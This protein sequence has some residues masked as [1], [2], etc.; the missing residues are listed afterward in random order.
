MHRF[1]PHHIAILERDD[2]DVSTPADGHHAGSTR[3]NLEA[4]RID[5]ARIAVD[6]RELHDAI[7]ELHGLRRR[8]PLGVL[9]CRAGGSGRQ[10]ECKDRKAHEP[11]VRRE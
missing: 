6:Q 7:A 3:E 11:I 9:R 8:E 10:D 2:L 5:A 4:L 1:T